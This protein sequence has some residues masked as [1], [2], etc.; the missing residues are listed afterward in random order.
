M[1]LFHHF[2]ERQFELKSK[3]KVSSIAT[4]NNEFELKTV[5]FMKVSLLIQ[6]PSDGR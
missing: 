6:E 1:L 2:N 5:T 3:R 4:R